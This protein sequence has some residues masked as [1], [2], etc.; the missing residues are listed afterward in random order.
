[1]ARGFSRRPDRA[2]LA[3]NV[4]K[5]R[6]RSGWSQEQLAAA[7]GE[8]RQAVISEIETG[9]ANPTMVTLE[10]IAA[11]LGVRVYDLFRPQR[12]QSVRRSSS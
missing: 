4:K 10:H 11:A 12:A 6:I 3:H 1:M 5:L 9:K 8:M 2:A 7:A